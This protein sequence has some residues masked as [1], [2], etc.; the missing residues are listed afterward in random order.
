MRQELVTSQWQKMGNSKK[1]AL[2]PKRCP[3][4]FFRLLYRAI[5]QRLCCPSSS[6]LEYG[7]EGW[8]S[9][10]I[11]EDRDVFEKKIFFKCKQ[12]TWALC[13][14]THARQLMR[15]STA[16]TQLFLIIDWKVGS[17]V[18]KMRFRTS[19]VQR[20]IFITRW[21]ISFKLRHAHLL[22]NNNF[23]FFSARV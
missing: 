6:D 7:A 14:Q 19:C 20:D 10:S 1:I 18:A 16:Q 12:K 4:P 3:D 13:H 23:S 11:A 22:T 9:L 21:R 5:L 2:F 8:V 17:R 15:I